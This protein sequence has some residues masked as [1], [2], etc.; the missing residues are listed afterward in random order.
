MPD[1]LEKARLE[2]EKRRELWQQ[3]QKAR[4]AQKLKE[5]SL[6][7]AGDNEEEKGEKGVEAE[8]GK[9]EVQEG[10]FASAMAR[11]REAKRKKIA[12]EKKLS[13]NESKGIEGKIE[14]SQKSLKNLKNI[15]R[16][17]N[18]TSAV[19]VVGI[20]IT[21]LV[22]NAQLFFGNLLKIDKIPALSF[23]ELLLV[24]LVDFI[25]ILTILTALVFI[26]AAV[27]LI[28]E[29]PLIKFLTD[30]FNISMP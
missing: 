7:L 14:E 4:M 6:L 18:G 27:G 30:T 25:L 29:H 11:V 12:R 8:E 20:I 17:I 22:M 23:W 21:F 3:Q 15:Y 26:I 2:Q 28:L 10:S 16:I 24:L 13:E 9:G 19:T 5:R 1:Y